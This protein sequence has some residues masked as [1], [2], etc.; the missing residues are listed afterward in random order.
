GS[1]HIYGVKDDG[2]VT[3]RKKSEFASLP[4]P[5]EEEKLRRGMEIFAREGV[6][7]RVWIAPGNAFD[8]TTVSLLPRFGMDIVSAGWFWG[9]FIGPHN[10]T[11]MPCP[12][13]NLRSVPSGVWSV[14]HHVNWT[15]RS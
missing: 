8:E 9:P 2:V 6:K 15:G 13:S 1:E 10:T 5:V 3:W 12:L 4:S 11:W 7:S 14:C